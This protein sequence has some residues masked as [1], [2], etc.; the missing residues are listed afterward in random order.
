[1]LLMFVLLLVSLVVAGLVVLYV[2][3]PHRGEEMPVVPVLGEAMRSAADAIST[4][5]DDRVRAGERR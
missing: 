4:L 3:Y 1:M 5:D 2:A